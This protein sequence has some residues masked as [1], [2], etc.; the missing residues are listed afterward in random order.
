M[1]TGIS[2]GGLNAGYLSFFRDNITEFREGVGRLSKLWDDM[3]TADVYERDILRFFSQWSIYNTQPLRRTLREYLTKLLR[4][5]SAVSSNSTTSTY[6]GATNLNSGHL[7][8]FQ[9][10][11]LSLDDKLESLIA[12]SAVPFLFPPV[13]WEK[14]LYVDGGVIADELIWD[15]LDEG[16]CSEYNVVVILANE[17]SFTTDIPNSVYQYL[18]RVL[19]FVLHSFNSQLTDISRKLRHYK[20]VN[21]VICYPEWSSESELNKKDY[22]PW[23]FDNGSVLRK[24]GKSHYRCEHP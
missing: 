9:F 18:H 3:K 24:L 19:S 16:E 15:V 7:D 6:I 20:N 5:T 23:N 13:E 22:S 1:I 14:S 17:M 10:E 11:Q 12:T 2:A 8:I 4:D 21:M